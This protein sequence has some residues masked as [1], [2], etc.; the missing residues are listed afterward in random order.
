[1]PFTSFRNA[2]G[3]APIANPYTSAGNMRQRLRVYIQHK[4][5]LRQRSVFKL[6]PNREYLRNIIE[7]CAMDGIKDIIRDILCFTKLLSILANLVAFFFQSKGGSPPPP[8][9]YSRKNL[10]ER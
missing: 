9:I 6:F 5:L 3:A 2:F 8:R 4:Q 10:T 7:A 1:M